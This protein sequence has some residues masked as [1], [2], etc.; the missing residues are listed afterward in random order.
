MMT[1]LLLPSIIRYVKDGKDQNNPRYFTS[2]STDTFCAAWFHPDGIQTVEVPIDPLHNS[3]ATGTSRISLL[4]SG[5]IVRGG[6]RNRNGINNRNIRD[7]CYEWRGYR[8]ADQILA[9]FGY[10]KLFVEQVM[11]VLS[12]NYKNI[13]Q[14]GNVN[15]DRSKNKKNPLYQI[16]TASVRGATFA[17]P[18]AYCTCWDDNIDCPT[19]HNNNNNKLGNTNSD[20]VSYSQQEIELRKYSRLVR[21]ERINLLH[22]QLLPRVIR[23]SAF[24][25]AVCPSLSGQQQSA[26]QFLNASGSSA[27]RLLTA[28]FKCGPLYGPVTIAVVSIA[29]EDGCFLSG[30]KRRCE[31]GHMY[32]QRERDSLIDMSP[33]CVATNDLGGTQQQHRHHHE[34]HLTHNIKTKYDFRDENSDDD[35]SSSINTSDD[36]RE[37]HADSSCNECDCPFN[38]NTE[39]YDG[40]ATPEEE[41]QQKPPNSLY[42]GGLGPGKWH[43][44]VAIVD[45]KNTTIRIDGAEEKMACFKN[46]TVVGE[47]QEGVSSSFCCLDGLTIGS[48]SSFDMS[49]C[50]GEGAPGEGDG[51]IAEL[52]VFQGRL[53]KEYDLKVL[54]MYLMKKHG[55]SPTVTSNM[56]QFLQQEDEW[57]RDS[58]ALIEQSSPYEMVIPN[59]IPLRVVANDH[60]VAWHRINNVTGER[61]NVGRIGSRISTGSSDW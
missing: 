28:P 44:Y 7:S 32:P 35:D 39:L 13:S 52:V 56:Q 50:F 17:R 22:R 37:V 21:R 33:V 42:Q 4:Y 31:F 6:Q 3:T 1:S 57:K 41:E 20:E 10:S 30:L 40:N 14:N 18:E 58:R 24:K 29:T 9:P 25:N 34:D 49:L 54:E 15:D 5:K 51:S 19:S 53:E 60:T 48:D 23:T 45:G 12:S 27:V 36:E 59:S 55:I 46:E 38:V 43:C 16:T 2:N 26:I 61:I 11:A 47:Q 8:N